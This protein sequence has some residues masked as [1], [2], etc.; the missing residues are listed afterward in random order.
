M[1]NPTKLGRG[2]DALLGGAVLPGVSENRQGVRS[3]AI[4]RLRR[5]AFQPRMDIDE[6]AISELAD[7][8]RV[9]GIIQPILARQLPDS[10]GY[11]IIAG[12]RRWRAAQLAELHEVPVIVR[13]VADQQAMAMA[14]IENVQREDL[15]PV[16]EASMLKRLVDEFSLSHAQV[17][18]SV[19]KSRATITNLIRLLNLEDTVLQ[20][21]KNGD[22][23]TGHAKVLLALKDQAQVDAAMVVVKRSLNVRMTEQL[24]KSWHKTKPRT[25]GRR[26]TGDAD[27]RRLETAIADRIEAKVSI[28]DVNGKGFIKISYRNLDQLDAILERM[29]IPKNEL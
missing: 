23:E 13:E 8:V 29:R 4:E 14:L 17:A 7:S 28:N 21:L 22:I 12:E 1:S 25:P 6:E 9:H 18:E 5:S 27:I 11:E 24:V 3:V 26:R 15:N 20:L 19:G 16:E 10:D 2:L